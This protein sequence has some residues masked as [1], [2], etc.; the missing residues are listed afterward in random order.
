MDNLHNLLTSPLRFFVSFVI[1][2]CLFFSLGCVGPWP[3]ISVDTQGLGKGQIAD[4]LRKANWS[5]DEERLS[6]NVK[7]MLATTNKGL[8]PRAS[9]ESIGMVCDAPPSKKCQYTGFVKHQA[10]GTPKENVDAGKPKISFF[11]ITLPNCDEPNSLVV[12]KTTKIIQQ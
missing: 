10:H 5:F 2:F 4:F 3:S 7:E 8:S 9:A 1:V 6:K 11:E 12:K